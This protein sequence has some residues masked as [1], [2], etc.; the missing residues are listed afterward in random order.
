GETVHLEALR[1][2]DHWQPV[3]LWHPRAERLAKASRDQGL[4]GTTEFEALLADP[5]IDAVVIATPP[6]PRYTLAKAALQAGKHLML[7]KPVGLHAEDV[8]DLQRLALAN[9]LSVAVDFEYRAVPLF[10]QLA[11]LL[12]QGVLGEPWLVKL[13][14][15]MA[16]RADARRPWSWYSSAAEG[17]G[18]LGALGTHAFDLLHWLVG[19]TVDLK[20]QLSTAI[21]HRPHPSTGAATRVDAE[22]IALIQLQLQ[23]AQGQTVPAQMNLASVTRAG[24]GCWLELYGSEATLVL[25]SD[26]QAD[27]VHGF[28]L[29]MARPGEPLRAVAADPAL[30]FRRTWGDGRIAPVERLH[31]WWAEAIQARRP[32]VPGLLE[33]LSSQH[34]CDQARQSTPTR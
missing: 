2:S 20:A 27:Y 8:A 14:W 11:Q 9:G 28:G 33:A 29:W 7:E 18:V 22:D 4:S 6:A 10:Q 31:G 15:L 32:M 19:P 26:N 12:Q 13:D 17:G 23:G 3:A 25:G 24:R 21:S 16:S 30:A 1:N 34:C 5:H